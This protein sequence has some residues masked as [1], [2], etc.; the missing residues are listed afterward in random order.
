MITPKLRILCVYSAS[1]TY[2]STVFEHLLSFSRNSSNSWFYLDIN[3][4]DSDSISLDEFDSIVIHYSVR[5]PFGQLTESCVEKLRN[6]PRLKTLFIQDEYDGTN[7][8]LRIINSVPFDLVFSVVPTNSLEKIY[9][10]HTLSRT[11]FVNNLTGY[12]PDDLINQVNISNLPSERPLIIGYRARELLP[13]YGRLGQEKFLIGQHVKKYCLTH[14]IRCDIKL[15]DRSRIYGGKWYKFISSMR[16]MLGTESGS[17]VFDWDS[18]LDQEINSYRRRFPNSTDQDIYLNLIKHHEIDGLMNQVSPKIFEMAAAKTV[19]VLFE[20]NYS[21]VLE[22]HIHFFPLKK[23]FSNLD[24]MITFLKDNDL[25]DAM[26]ERAHKDVI[27]SGKYSYK[28]FILMVDNE[29]N[30]LF[31]E[32]GIQHA[33]CYSGAQIIPPSKLTKIPIQFRRSLLILL[34]QYI[35]GNPFNQFKLFLKS[36]LPLSTQS[37]IR[38]LLKYL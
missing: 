11:R 12:A 7:T 33:A 14:R 22:P 5:L 26:A 38:K 20:G 8:A 28:E 34:G 30:S 4:F 21:G 36:H 37:H 13:R 15:D 24:Q 9:P 18:S 3:E 16:A 25:I 35:F 10:K 19:M 23:D 1:Q 27:L 31:K 29:M 17:N 2:T 32:L 6:F